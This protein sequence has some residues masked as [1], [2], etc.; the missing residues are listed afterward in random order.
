MKYITHVLLVAALLMSGCSETETTSGKNADKSMP[1]PAPAKPVPAPQVKGSILLYGEE[2][3]GVDPYQVTVYVT[4]N[5][6]RFEDDPRVNSF[7]LYDRKQRVIYSVSAENA[8]ILTIH[9]QPVEKL[10]P[11]EGKLAEMKMDTE[12]PQVAGYPSAH[13]QYRLNDQ[14]CMNVFSVDNLMDN[15]TQ[16]YQ[17]YRETLATEQAAALTVLPMETQDPCELVLNVYEPLRTLAQGLSIMEWND[18]GFRRSL[19]DYKEDTLIDAAKFELPEGFSTTD[20]RQMRSGV[21]TP[22]Q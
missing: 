19:L 6:I 4:D 3:T 18:H 8:S 22:E 20:T 10:P 13:Y 21:A 17:E 2:E 14:V 15:V 9:H 5:F 1:S 11:F 7:V 12:S 16:A